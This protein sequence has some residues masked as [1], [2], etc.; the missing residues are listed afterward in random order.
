MNTG[1]IIETENLLLKPGNNATDNKPFIEMLRRDGNFKDF[2]GLP[3]SERYLSSFEDYFEHINDDQCLF[4]IH[5]KEKDIFIGYV[6]FH[7]ERDGYEL[8]F[9]IGKQ[10]RRKGFCEEACIAI[11]NELFNNGISA[12][13][14]MIIEGKLYASTLPD[15]VAAIALLEKLGFENE[16]ISVDGAV[17]VAQ[18]IYDEENDEFYDYPVK[19]YVIDTSHYEGTYEISNY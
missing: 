13:G 14:N 4:S 6:G 18:G 1:N 2:C 3:F 8:E 9:Y 5:P 11:I 17:L 12:N 16:I 7:R 10:F 15:N 19:R